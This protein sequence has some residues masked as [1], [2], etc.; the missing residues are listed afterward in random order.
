MR[1]AHAPQ[2]L[3]VTPQQPAHRWLIVLLDL[4]TTAFHRTSL[5]EGS[6]NKVS[7]SG[8]RIPQQVDILSLV[9]WG[10]QEM[11]HGPIMPDVKLA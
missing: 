9:F 11:Q 7:T 3:E 10:G 6:N 4:Q 8:K 2:V 5:R 1:I